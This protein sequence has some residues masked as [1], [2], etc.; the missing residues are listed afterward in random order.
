MRAPGRKS[1]L[2]LALTFSVLLL[3]NDNFAITRPATSP[4]IDPHGPPPPPPENPLPAP[5]SPASPDL[6]SRSS[7]R[8]FVVAFLHARGGQSVDEELGFF[9]AR[10]EYLGRPDVSREKIRRDLLRIRERWPE[11][12]FSLAGDLAIENQKNGRISVTFSVRYE[13]RK[14]V[15][16]R[17]GEVRQTLVLAR[18][19]PNELQIVAL[20]ERQPGT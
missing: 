3:P 18:T 4:I 7:L 16:R 2:F 20:Q 8:H 6:F 15:S 5:P 11:R 13:L 12:Q 17:Q 14:G 9:A 1:F 10:A 19:S